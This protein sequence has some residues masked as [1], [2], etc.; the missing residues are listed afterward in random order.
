MNK[1]E[2][3]AWIITGV[4]LIIATI[5]IYFQVRSIQNQ[6]KKVRERS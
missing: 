5:K 4:L 3:M 6:N 2:C 1:S